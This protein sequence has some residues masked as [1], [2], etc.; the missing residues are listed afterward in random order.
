MTV[1]SKALLGLVAGFALAWSP[2]VSQAEY[3]ERPITLVAPYGPGGASDLSARMVAGAAPQYLGQPILAV[4]KTGAAGVVGSNFVVNSQPDGYTLLSAR[5]G[6]QMGVPAMNKTIP[7]AWDDF[8]VLGLIELNPFVLVV[9]PDSGI[10]TFSDFQAKITA[11]EEMSYSSA[12]VGT[13]LHIAVAV[14]ANAM[15]ADFDALTHVPY[16][17]GGKARAAVVAGQVDFSFQNLSA[18]A[19]ALEAGQLTALVVTMDERQPIIPD[20]PT[21][22]EVGQPDLEKIVGWSAIYGPPDL[23]DDVVAKWVETLQSLKEDK[24]WNRM[25]KG[26]GN[27]VDIRSPEETR[28]FVEA[29]YT[30]FDDTLLKLG[31]R[32]E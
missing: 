6:S 25:T 29:Q 12:G 11:G 5:V 27:I 14:M 9:N 17:G 20:V 13:L 8:T 30:I 3:P 4:N 19:G 2:A 22:A 16:K 7:Y 15:G 1:I 31:L 18:V 26:L 21:A 28:A 23:P 10:E 24:A 32:I